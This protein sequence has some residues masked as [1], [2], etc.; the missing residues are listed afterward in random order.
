MRPSGPTVTSLRSPMPSI[1]FPPRSHAVTS[2]N[3]AR[4]SC[5]V[6]NSLARAIADQDLMGLVADGKKLAVAAVPRRP[7]ADPRDLA[8][9]EVPHLPDVELFSHV[10]GMPMGLPTQPGQRPPSRLTYL[11]LCRCIQL[12]ASWEFMPHG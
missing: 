9:V 2:R 5:G 6:G 10:T 7:F 12:N 11:W 4:D 8:Q 1:A 3:V